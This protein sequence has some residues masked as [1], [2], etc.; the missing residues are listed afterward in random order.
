MFTEM[1]GPTFCRKLPIV[2]PYNS[3]RTSSLKEIY[4]GS[5]DDF[6]NSVKVIFR[7]YKF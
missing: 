4:P 6:F 3:K 1:N 5:N 2:F 7:T